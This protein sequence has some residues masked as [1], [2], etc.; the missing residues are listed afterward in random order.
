MAGIRIHRQAMPVQ[1]FARWLAGITAVALGLRLFVI[2]TSSNEAVGGDGYAYSNEANANAAGH[3]FLSVFTGRPDAI[4]PPVWSLILTGWAALGEH[5]EFR[6]QILAACIGTCTVALVGVAG[7]RIAGDRVGLVAA[8]IAAVYAGLWLYERALLSETFLFVVIALMLIIAYWFHDRPSIRRA[9]LLGAMTGLVAMTRSE[10]ILLFPLLV[11]PLI[12]SVW[13]VGWRTRILW[14]VVAALATAVVIAPWTIYNLGRFKDPIFLSTNGGGAAA[15]ANCNGTYSGP[16]IG[17]YDIACY[18]KHQ[19]SDPSIANGQDVRYG[20]T[21]AEHHL[22]RLPEVVFAREGRAFGYWNPFQQTYLDNRW[23]TVSPILGMKT[24][25]WVYDLRLVS[26]WILLL[27]ALGGVV[28]LR[29]RRILTYPLLTF[30]LV[31]VITVATAYG[32]TRY[33]AAAEVP[34]V[35]LAGVGIE[36]VLPRNRRRTEAGADVAGGVDDDPPREQDSELLDPAV[37][38]QR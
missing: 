21:Y 31:V 38:S 14:L 32:E 2:V 10:E 24:T 37:G 36:A 5:S 12:V 18:P 6:Q 26:Y 30:F 34:L 25:V 7:R 22:S 1:H 19:S 35:I 13:A 15:T 17:W 20:L 16:Y 27:P 29:R 4:H 3:W 33:R 23:Q 8:A 11:L 28:V 9:A